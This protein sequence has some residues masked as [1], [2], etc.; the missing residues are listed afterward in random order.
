MPRSKAFQ[1]SLLACMWSLSGGYIRVLQWNMTSRMFPQRGGTAECTVNPT[2]P[3]RMARIGRSA[4]PC[5][6]KLK[7][8]KENL[9]FQKK[10]N[11]PGA[12]GRRAKPPSASSCTHHLCVGD[13][14]QQ[15]CQVVSTQPLVGVVELQATDGSSHAAAGDHGRRVHGQSVI[16]K[17]QKY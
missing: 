6:R 10:K 9:C 1:R 4:S 3:A 7:P 11:P 2:R 17:R 14:S 12:C 15:L 13:F 16:C 5:G 8:A